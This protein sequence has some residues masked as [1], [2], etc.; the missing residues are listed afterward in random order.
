MRAEILGFWV[1][2]G[3]EFQSMIP[4]SGLF[5]FDYS[6]IYTFQHNKT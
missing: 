1:P 3:F 4:S 5:S 6:T 2:G